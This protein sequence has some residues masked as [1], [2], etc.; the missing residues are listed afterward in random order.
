MPTVDVDFAA[1]ARHAVGRCLAAGR[2]RIALLVHLTELAGDA[3]IFE[4][5][6]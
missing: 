6:Y 2:S 5:G 1:T 3:I 4:E